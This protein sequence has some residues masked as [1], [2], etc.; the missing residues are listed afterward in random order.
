MQ[1]QV[2]IGCAAPLAVEGAVSLSAEDPL[3]V[4]ADVSVN[5]KVTIGGKVDIQGKVKPTLL[6]VPG[7]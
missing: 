6:P 3:A 4:R 1:E 7:I 2:T 5:N